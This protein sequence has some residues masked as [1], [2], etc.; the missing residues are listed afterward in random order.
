M[1]GVLSSPKVLIMTNVTQKGEK[2]SS[3]NQC[4]V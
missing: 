1:I 2:K 3:P 4:K